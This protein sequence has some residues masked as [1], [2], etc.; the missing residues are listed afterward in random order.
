MTDLELLRK[1]VELMGEQM[2]EINFDVQDT[3]NE[4][5]EAMDQVNSMCKFLKYRLLFESVVRM[6]KEDLDDD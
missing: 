3:L 5:S 4:L 1:K 6:F 2:N